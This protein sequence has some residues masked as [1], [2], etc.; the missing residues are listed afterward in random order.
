[1]NPLSTINLYILN[2]L[3][4]NNFIFSPKNSYLMLIGNESENEI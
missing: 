4:I 2:L 3:R 1:M